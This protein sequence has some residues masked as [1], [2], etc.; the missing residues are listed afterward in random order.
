VA[1]TGDSNFEPDEQFF[2]NL[3]NPVNGV[4]VDAQGVGTILTDDL[5]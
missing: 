4:L 3:S 5:G 1:V 2:V